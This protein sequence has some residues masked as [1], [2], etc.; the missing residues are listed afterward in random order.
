MPGNPYDQASRY[1]AKLEPAPF[2]A[3]LMGIPPTDLIF[4][5]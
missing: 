1:L 5:G 3:W 4:R 2:I